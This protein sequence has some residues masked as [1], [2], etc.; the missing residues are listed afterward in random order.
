MKSEQVPG[1]DEALVSA[2]GELK[3]GLLASIRYRVRDPQL[4]EDLLQDVFVKALRLAREGRTPGNLAAWLHQVVRTTVIDHYR[5][6][7]PDQVPLED[8]PAAVEPDEDLEAF[9]ALA[10]CM[11]PLVDTLPSPYRETL[12]AADFEGRTHAAIAAVSGKVTVSAIKTRV[13]R[14]RRMLRERLLACCDLDRGDA[15]QLVGF[16]THSRQACA[17]DSG[18]Q[19]APADRSYGCPGHSR[20]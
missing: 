7:P 6:K 14:A 9:Q 8:E 3:R 2:Y 13:S 15:G 20:R 10:S 16:R 11:Q 18:P 1:Q 4:S 19:E 5:S 17:C 12:L